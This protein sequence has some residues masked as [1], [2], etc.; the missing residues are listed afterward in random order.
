MFSRNTA[1]RAQRHAFNTNGLRRIACAI[2]GYRGGDGNIAYRETTDLAGCRDI[3]LYQRRRHHQT[4]C[5]VVEA[6]YR[7]IGRQQLLRIDGQ[8]KQI[9]D[10]VLVFTRVQTMQRRCTGIR[11]P[12]GSR[13]QILLNRLQKSGK[14]RMLRLR[15]ARRRHH[16]YTCLLEYPL[17]HFFASAHG[18]ERQ[19]IKRQAAGIVVNV[20]TTHAVAVEESFALLR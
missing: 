2:S 5:D 11:I 10:R 7:I 15:L 14:L 16:A 13:C 18:V 6:L 20:V 19:Q 3:G 1:A 17:P 12:L 8:I 9:T 4:F